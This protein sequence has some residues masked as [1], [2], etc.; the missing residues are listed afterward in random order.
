MML[1][2]R[3]SERDLFWSFARAEIEIPGSGIRHTQ[4]KISS[5][6][7]ELVVR[8]ERAELSEMDW[9]ALREAVLSVRSDPVQPLLDLNLQWFLGMFPV[10]EWAT[11]KVMNLQIFTRIAPSRQLLELATALDGGEVPSVGSR[12]SAPSFRE[13]IGTASLRR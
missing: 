4:P 7:R 6:L 8:N 10:E 5:A 11:L 13:T 2:Q 9:V 12:N 1:L 3:G